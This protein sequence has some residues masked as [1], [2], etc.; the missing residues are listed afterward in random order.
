MRRWFSEIAAAGFQQLEELSDTLRTAVNVPPHNN[1]QRILLSRLRFM[2]D[3]ILTTPVVRRLREAYPAAE[4]VYL[5]ESAFVPLLAHNPHVDEVL[6]FSAQWPLAQQMRFYRELRR[7]GF[8]LAIDLFGNPR[9]ALMTWIT[10]AKVRIGG[11][12]RGRGKLYNFRVPP[13]DGEVSAIDF[14]LR[15]LQLLGLKASN[16]QTEIFLT[17]DERLWAQSFLF[18]QNID[19][20]QPVVAL[21]PGAT[22]PHKRWP[23]KYFAEVSNHLQKNGVQVVVTQGPDEA[24]IVQE[25]KRL[26]PA[27]TILPVLSLRETA[28]LQNQCNAVVAND[29]GIMHLAVAVGTPTIGL[30]GP[31]QKEIWFPY[32]TTK[33]HL[34]L[35]IP[36]DCRPCHK[37]YCPLQ[38]TNCQNLLLPLRVIHEVMQRLS[39]QVSKTMG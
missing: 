20:A 12:F 25:V 8:D 3:V 2:G 14:H 4:I 19:P 36:M 22:W 16:K 10:G 29:C 38:H 9:T 32:E 6:E 1:F 15:S 28:A 18:L 34:A 26:S 39:K 11:D 33:K 37:N 30:F 24:G 23:E 35:D 17:P 21:H 7:R 5:T 13:P 27:A 31:S